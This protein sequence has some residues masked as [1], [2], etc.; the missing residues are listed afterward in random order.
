MSIFSK[1][2]QEMKGI[3]LPSFGHVVARYLFLVFIIV[4][5]SLLCAGVD[6]TAIWLMKSFFRV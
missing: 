2:F 1:I 5:C 4:I 6:K 3:K